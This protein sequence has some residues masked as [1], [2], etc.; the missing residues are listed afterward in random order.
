MVDDLQVIKRVLQ[1]GLNLSRQAS[2]HR[3][4]PSPEA[5]PLLH[6]ARRELKL[7]IE[8]N[9]ERLDALR[10][11]AIAE[12]ALLHYDGA[13]QALEKIIRISNQP[14]RKDLKRLAACREASNT[15]K[16][17]HLHPAELAALGEYLKSR[18]LDTAPERSL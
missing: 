8:Q 1:Q 7:W 9:G 4:A 14:D 15:W 11:L 10:S 3:R 12:E 6:E 17:L 18:L 13:V 2:Y 16:Q 5:L